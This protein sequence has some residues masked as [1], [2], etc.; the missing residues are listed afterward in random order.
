MAES[1]SLRAG[2]TWTEGSM[3]LRIGT[4]R[5]DFLFGTNDSDLLRGRGGHDVLFARGGDDDLYGDRG[6]DLMIGGD[7]T[8]TFHFKPGTG[9]DV[10]ADL[11][12][13]SQGDRVVLYGVTED[14]I[15]TVYNAALNTTVLFIDAPG[16]GTITFLGESETDVLSA[17]SFQPIEDYIV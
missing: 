11:H 4:P 13:K 9:H 2:D 15:H 3:A 16:G 17:I 12:V 7:G 1:L 14:D 5:T 10:V 6:N 8:D